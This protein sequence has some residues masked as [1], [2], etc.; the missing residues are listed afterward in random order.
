MG[1]NRVKGTI[2]QVRIDGLPITLPVCKGTILYVGIFKDTVMM[3]FFMFMFHA[4]HHFFCNSWY[5]IYQTHGLG[6]T[7]AK[8]GQKVFYPDIIFAAGIDKQIC[9]LNGFD[10][11]R[12]WLKG[13]AF[14]AG[15][16]QQCDICLVFGNF[17]C[18]IVGREDRGYNLYIAA[19]KGCRLSG[20]AACRKK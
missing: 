10:I 11:L 13:V 18:E 2:Q 1:K 20:N 3:V 17:P 5:A 4:F 7:I 16:E 8:R 6:R 19:G 12:C 15:L 9:I 14:C